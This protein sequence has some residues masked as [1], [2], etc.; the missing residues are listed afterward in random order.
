MA[1][2][3][4]RAAL[5]DRRSQT[6]RAAGP[7]RFGTPLLSGM[8]QVWSL[9]NSE[10]HTPDNGKIP[11]LT[12]NSKLAMSRYADGKLHGR[13]QCRICVKI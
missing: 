5:R 12:G 1:L 10:N 3:D 6:N 7:R 2:M 13:D 11:H 8:Q 4:G 9:P